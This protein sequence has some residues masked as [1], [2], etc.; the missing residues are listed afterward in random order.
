MCLTS[1]NS[2]CIY[3]L[4]LLSNVHNELRALQVRKLMWDINLSLHAVGL[5]HR[6]VISSVRG[7]PLALSFSSLCDELKETSLWL[8]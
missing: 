6:G 4:I 8:I 7:R 3:N 1:A 2:R 5:L